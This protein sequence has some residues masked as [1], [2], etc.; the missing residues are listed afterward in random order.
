MVGCPFEW[1]VDS[2]QWTGSSF[3]L[4]LV[5]LGGLLPQ[6]LLAIPTLL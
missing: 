2:G 1:T 4:I 5:N 6:L 3:P